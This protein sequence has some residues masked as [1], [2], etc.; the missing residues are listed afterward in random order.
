[1]FELRHPDGIVEEIRNFMFWNPDSDDY[2]GKQRRYQEVLARSRFVLCPRGHGTSS[3]RLYETMAAG[4]V[5]VIISDEWVAPPGPDWDRFSLR[6]AES[7]AGLIPEVLEQ[8]DDAWSDMAAA[9]AAAF[10]A[11][12][13]RAVGFHRIADLLAE[14]RTARASA[15]TPIRMRG[16]LLNA[17]IH[18]SRTLRGLQKLATITRRRNP[19]WVSTR[20]SG[21]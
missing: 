2:Q 16:R 7:E 18:E 4:R 21:T 9:A 20:F 13:S 6:V 12:F 10:D 8:R 1:L 15:P 14:L 11:H 3:I 5:P 19:A 17:N